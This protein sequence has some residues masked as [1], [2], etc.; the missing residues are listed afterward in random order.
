MRVVRVDDTTAAVGKDLRAALV[1]WGRGDTVAGGVALLGVRPPGCPQVL[2]AVLVLPRG[3]LVV[4]CVDLP[5]PAMRL[6]APLSEQWKT[7]GWPLVSSG[8]PVNPA[9]DALAASAAVA[10]RLAAERVEPLP[11]GTVVAVGPYV[12]QVSQPSADLVRG[13]RI[14]HPE[15]MTLLTAARELATHG[16]ACPVGELRRILAALH[17]G[18]VVDE[19]EL[20]AEGFPDGFSAAAAA[21][22]TTVIP[23]ITG[24]SHV[25]PVPRK[26]SGK[27]KWLP[28]VAA[29][30]VAVLLITG[31]VVAVNS[32]GDPQ[33]QSPGPSSTRTAEI[34]IE[35]TTF[36]PKGAAEHPDCATHAFGDVRAWL[37]KNGCAR[38]I[39]ARFEVA[40]GGRQAAVLV[41]VLRFTGSS[42]ATE[43]RAVADKPG[44]GGIVDQAA[45]GVPW[46]GDRKPKFESAAYVSGR[47]GNSV[48]LV[49][50]VW[51]DGSSRPDDEALK[52]IAGRALQLSPAG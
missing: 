42:L 10:E 5:D 21:E 44:S 34:P 33:A 3:I 40:D 18:L 12:S 43:L 19:T 24:G 13:V 15:P 1:S 9:V 51:L 2:D 22:S 39:R 11:V 16:R 27:L 26:A 30:L 36:T 48:K 35:G 45:E 49:Q 52:R 17:P 46:P 23:R 4:V 32:A 8:G 37:E 50:A 7:D 28:I 31:I 6:D 47:E 14:L 25:P 38:L 41:A 29:A 20:L